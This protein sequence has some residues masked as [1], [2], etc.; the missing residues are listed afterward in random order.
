L[1]RRTASALNSQPIR[2][3]SEIQ[4]LISKIE[5]CRDRFIAQ[6]GGADRARCLC[7]IFNEIKAGNGGS[8]PVIDDWLRMY[9][10]LGCG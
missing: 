5:G 8:L 1:R 4:E 10:Q 2:S 7:S 6:G 9:G 3:D